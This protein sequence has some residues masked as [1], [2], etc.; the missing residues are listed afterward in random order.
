MYLS[1]EVEKWY[2]SLR[3]AD[4]RAADR[5]LDRLEQQGPE[6][7]MPH[8]KPLGDG[9]RELR[10]SCENA[11]R[12]ITYTLDP[13]NKAITLTT[14]RKQKQNER[15]EVQRARRALAAHRSQNPDPA[16]DRSSRRTKR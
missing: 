11:E 13:N 4:V 2:R 12:R 9:L 10:F 1:K 5:A 8:A 6:V 7:T 14:F 3:A 16:P 15:R